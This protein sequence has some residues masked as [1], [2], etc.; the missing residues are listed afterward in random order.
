[1]KIL[2]AA[3]MA[4][5]DLLRAT[6]SL[7]SRVTKWSH[8]CDV[9]LHRLVCYIHHSKKMFLQGFVGDSFDECQ[10]WLFADTDFAGEND[11]KST[12]GCATV[13]VGPNTYFPL[14][15]FSRKQ[16]VTSMSSTEAEVVAANQSMRAEPTP[17]IGSKF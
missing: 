15:A 3:R 9:S 7:A 11:A 14:N 4:R 12:T 2:F 10:V 1:M 16:T 6:Q 8:E 5:F 13:I 17:P